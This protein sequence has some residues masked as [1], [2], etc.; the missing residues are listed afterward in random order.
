MNYDADPA[1]DVAMPILCGTCTSTSINNP[2]AINADPVLQAANRNAGGWVFKGVM[3]TEL[4]TKVLARY[5]LSQGSNGDVNGDGQL[6]IVVYGADETFVRGFAVG[7]EQS[8]ASLRPPPGA[9]FEQILI[10][11]AIDPDAYDWNT[12]L[13]RINDST[14]SSRDVTG[15]RPDFLANMLRTNM[16]PSFIRASAGST[17]RT[18]YGTTARFDGLVRDL[19]AAADGVEGVSHVFVNPGASSELFLRE[20]EAVYG[21]PAAYRSPQLYD[22]GFLASLAIVVATMDLEDPTTVTPAQLAAALRSVQDPAGEVITAGAAEFA[23]AVELLRAG[24]TINYEGASGPLDFDANAAVRNDLA[25]Y[26][27]RNGR[28][29]DLEVFDCISGDDCAR[30]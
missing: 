5:L 4:I 11:L 10:P 28:F 22:L 14:N 3:S 16:F 30:R 29:E 26:Q 17:L 25:R 9:A 2:D 7:L 12:D 13:G 18:V 8:I 23:R 24:K 21:I 20:Y 27:V 15:W 1:N 6:H 19:G